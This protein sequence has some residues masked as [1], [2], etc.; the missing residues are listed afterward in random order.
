[1]PTTSTSRPGS[2]VGRCRSGDFGAGT[3]ATRLAL[4]PGDDLDGVLAGID[5]RLLHGDGV[6]CVAVCST[7]PTARR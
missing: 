5:H 2:A 6:A 7:T 3:E 1:V 4:L